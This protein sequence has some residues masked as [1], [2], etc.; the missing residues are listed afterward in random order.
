MPGEGDDGEVDHSTFP[1]FG[2][3]YSRYAH[4]YIDAPV[5]EPADAPDV[6]ELPVLPRLSSAA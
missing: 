6:A 2:T 5:V 4:L 3:W 1:A